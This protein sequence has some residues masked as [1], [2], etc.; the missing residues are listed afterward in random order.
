MILLDAI[1]VNNGGAK[2]L[3][4]YIIE[5]LEK[6]DRSVFY[7]LDIRVKNNIPKIK[8]TNTVIY[9]KSSLYNRYKF[10]KNNSLKISVVLAFANLPPNIRLNCKV[11][12]YFHQKIFLKIPKEYSFFV[13][14]KFN[15]KV[16]VLKS[17]K[18]NTDFWIVQ[19]QLVKSKLAQKKN[20]DEDKILIL[21]FY[22]PFSEKIN[23]L[24]EKNT[25]LYVSNGEP[26]KN[27]KV[28]IDAFCQFYDKNELGKL[29]L[30]ISKHYKDVFDLI[31]EKKQLGYPIENIGFI[32]RNL[33]EVV[34]KKTEFLIFP[35]ISE[36]FGLG[37]VE[38]IDNGC[39]VIGAD[40][41]YT[42]EVCEPTLVFN[43][44]VRESIVQTLCLSLKPDLPHSIS[45]VHN[46]IAT[47]IDLLQ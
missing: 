41:Q 8:K 5:E 14:L 21:P 29:I 39:K 35:S 19:S 47:I 11:Y 7:L 17:L 15:L 24:R 38:A 12:T 23:P 32:D 34:Y 33:L 22:P 42:Y 44:N 31:E 16:L 40:L 2:V 3:L 45:K 10:Y 37:L 18:E 26:H 20:I 13:R 1:Y 9:L 25:Y 30:T 46:E 4:D 28:L 36:S 43:P 6:T 27:H